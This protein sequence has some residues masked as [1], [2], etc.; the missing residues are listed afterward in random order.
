MKKLTTLILLIAILFAL[1][2]AA[3]GDNGRNNSVGGG[4][5]VE[6]TPMP[7]GAQPILSAADATATYGA[8]QF[9]LQL[10]AIANQ[11]E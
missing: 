11:G 5:N 10:T 4:T 6:K 7:V 3:C 9:H 8:E 2:T 1:C